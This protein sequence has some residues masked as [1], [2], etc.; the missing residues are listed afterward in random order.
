MPKRKASDNPAPIIPIC[1]TMQ[2]AA[3]I[4]GL[5]PRKLYYLIKAGRLQT[6][7]V[8]RRRL[9]LYRS[10]LDDVLGTVRP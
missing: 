10:L 4:S 5:S 6:T 7:T 3:Q 9:V 2:R 1:I 8:D